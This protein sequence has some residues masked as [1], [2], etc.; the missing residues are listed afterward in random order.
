MLHIHL[1]CFLSCWSGILQ[2]LASFFS[3]LRPIM[4][5]PLSSHLFPLRCVLLPQEVISGFSP[6]ILHISVCS[7]WF[8]LCSCHFLPSRITIVSVSSISPSAISF[9]LP[10]SLWVYPWWVTCFHFH[11]SSLVHVAATPSSGLDSHFSIK[12]AATFIFILRRINICPTSVCLWILH[13]ETEILLLF[14]H[15]HVVPNICAVNF[16]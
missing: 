16:S 2:F 4:S 7:D 11:T 15:S 10:L 12:H 9:G 8:L 14:I 3:L 5:E 1:I 13:L 6:S